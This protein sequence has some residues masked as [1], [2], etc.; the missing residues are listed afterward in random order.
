MCVVCCSH[1][2]RESTWLFCLLLPPSPLAPL[3]CLCEPSSY[4][5]VWKG[6]VGGP[7]LDCVHTRC[8]VHRQGGILACCAPHTPTRT[9]HVLSRSGGLCATQRV[10]QARLVPLHLGW[11]VCHPLSPPR[12]SIPS[13]C[14]FLPTRLFTNSFFCTSVLKPLLAHSPRLLLYPSHV[15]AAPAVWFVVLCQLFPVLRRV[16]DTHPIVNPEMHYNHHLRGVYA[17]HVGLL[18]GKGTRASLGMEFPTPPVRC[19][20]IGLLTQ[21]GTGCCLEAPASL[22]PTC[23]S[24]DCFMQGGT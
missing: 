9:T 11:C 3:V 14:F 12:N 1:V 15:L 21:T 4:V 19:V 20:G 5:L 8:A 2:A 22:S 13:T 16:G 17:T 10:A 24:S 23:M 7:S 18:A 6:H